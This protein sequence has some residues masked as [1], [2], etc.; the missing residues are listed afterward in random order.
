[1]NKFIK[2]LLTA[3]L[4]FFISIP[5][6][7][8]GHMLMLRLLGGEGYIDYGIRLGK[9]VIL[10]EPPFPNWW[11]PVAAAGG[12]SV[13]MILLT[14]NYFINDIEISLVLQLTAGYQITYGILEVLKLHSI[15]MDIVVGGI[16]LLITSM[17]SMDL[18]EEI[19]K[20]GE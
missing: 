10:Q 13:A 14:L 2:L 11:V 6:H 7:E 20:C 8:N 18:L 4:L 1:M 16:G 15:P 9:V 5:I 12:G 19:M 17:Y 3:V